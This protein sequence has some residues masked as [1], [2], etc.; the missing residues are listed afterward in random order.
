MREDR[1]GLLGLALLPDTPGK[2]LPSVREPVNTAVGSR[3]VW[4]APTLGDSDGKITG[5]GEVEPL[6]QPHPPL[7]TSG[8][9]VREGIPGLHW[10][11][12]LLAGILFLADESISTHKLT[13]R[14]RERTP[15]SD[16]DCASRAAGKFTKGIKVP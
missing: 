13:S 8:F 12:P 3:D 1:K 14:N 6:R 4:A 16:E 15:R 9:T 2:H 10:L 7:P 11:R 5:V